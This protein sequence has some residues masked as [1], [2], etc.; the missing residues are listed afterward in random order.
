M[1][2]ERPSRR[3][4]ILD[5][6]AAMPLQAAVYSCPAPP[7][8]ARPACLQRMVVDLVDGAVTRLVIEPVQS[9][10]SAD[11]LVITRTMEKCNPQRELV[12][13]HL[14]ARAEP[15]LWAADAIAWAQGAGS[16]WR[17]RVGPVVGWDTVVVP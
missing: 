8:R 3:R 17:R 9:R 11:R 5:R 15:I 2:K 1:T 4:L 7:N 13:E 16:D 12:Y 14:V 10:V 6:I